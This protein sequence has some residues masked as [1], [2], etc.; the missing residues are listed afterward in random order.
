VPQPSKFNPPTSGK[1]EGLVESNEGDPMLECRNNDPYSYELG[2]RRTSHVRDRDYECHNF[3][4]WKDVDE[5]RGEETGY[6][7]SCEIDPSKVVENAS[8]A[9][10]FLD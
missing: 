1:S 2:R 8:K 3:G 10:N 6:K 9:F 7:G 4:L 5:Y